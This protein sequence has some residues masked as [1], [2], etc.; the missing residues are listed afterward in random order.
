MKIVFNIKETDA[1]TRVIADCVG[2]NAATRSDRARTGS[3][4]TASPASP[5][6]VHLLAVHG[7][8]VQVHCLDLAM[9]I[10]MITASGLSDANEALAKAR[11]HRRQDELEAPLTSLVWLTPVVSVVITYVVSFPIPTLGDGRCGGNSTVI[12]WHAGGRDHSRTGEG[13]H[14]DRVVSRRRSSTR[15]GGRRVAQH[16]V[17]LRRGNF[18]TALGLSIASLM[19]IGTASASGA[20]ASEC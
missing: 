15:Q 17:G 19:G 4:P 13:L 18:S 3:K 16:P 6:H 9:R 7:E 20:R 14:V 2:D 8:T 10:M 5:H 11:R 12:T 1:R